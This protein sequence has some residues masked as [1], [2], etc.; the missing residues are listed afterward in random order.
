MTVL[1]FFGTERAL[2]SFVIALTD[3][4]KTLH[5]ADPFVIKRIQLQDL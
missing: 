5:R 4:G 1:P 3:T 2:A